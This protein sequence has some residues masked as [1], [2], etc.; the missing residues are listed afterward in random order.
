MGTVYLSY[1][2]PKIIKLPKPLFLWFVVKWMMWSPLKF[3][4]LI[5]LLFVQKN[6]FIE[7]WGQL[8]VC[9]CF[10]IQA[11]FQ[12]EF[13]LTLLPMMHSLEKPFPPWTVQSDSWPQHRLP[14]NPSHT[15]LPLPPVQ[16]KFVANIL[17]I[18]D[19]SLVHSVCQ[20][21][22]S[23]TIILNPLEVLLRSRKTDFVRPTWRLVQELVF[24][25]CRWEEFLRLEV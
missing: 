16:K 8:A 6:C 12:P 10:G 19:H 2:K 13:S 9:L 4:P 3:S 20:H 11:L 23:C 14:P 17:R 25:R 18:V 24:L 7:I 22:C 5:N 15:L 21:A 1:I